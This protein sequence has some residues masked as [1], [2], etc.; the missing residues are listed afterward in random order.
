[1]RGNA[2]AR[3]LGASVERRTG[4]LRPGRCV[5]AEYHTRPRTIVVYEDALAVASAAARDERLQFGDEILEELAI[6]HECF[7]ILDPGGSEEGAHAFAAA[8]LKLPTSPAVLERALARYL[9]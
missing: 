4:G 7:H 2:L 5:L 9:A 3:R 8:F 1:M 6:A